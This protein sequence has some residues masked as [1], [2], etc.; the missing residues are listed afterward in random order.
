MRGDLVGAW[1]GLWTDNT[2]RRERLDRT[3]SKRD[4]TQHN[5]TRSLKKKTPGCDKG[6]DDE[7]EAKQEGLWTE[8]GE[9]STENG[10]RS[11]KWRETTWEEKQSG[12][13]SRT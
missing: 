7:K 11:G 5:A 9:R 10:A 13:R 1:E 2:A 4:K 3:K 8:D 6:Q 12:M